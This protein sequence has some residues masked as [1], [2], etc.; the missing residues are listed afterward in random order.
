MRKYSDERGDTLVETVL[1]MAV[2]SLVLL[3]SWALVHKATQISLAARQ[4]IEIVNRLKE[5]AEIIKGLYADNKTAITSRTMQST[6][7]GPVIN[8]GGTISSNPCDDSRLGTPTNAFYLSVDEAAGSIAP[9]MGV[10]TNGTEKVWVQLTTATGPEGKPYIDFHVRGCWQSF[11]I[12]QEEN[13]Q[14]RVRLNS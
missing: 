13:T 4:R 7:G 3:T 10:K 9:T 14:L 8:A 11:G 1:A 6:A 2:L 5:Q 12:Q